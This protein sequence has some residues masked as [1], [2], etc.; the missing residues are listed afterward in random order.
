MSKNRDYPKD[1]QGVYYDPQ[2]REPCTGEIIRRAGE[3][4][5]KSLEERFPGMKGNPGYC[6][7]LWIEKKNILLQKYGI[8]WKSPADLNPG[9][10]FD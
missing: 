4:A 10:R 5:V 3:E 6:R 8:D 9:I 2:E 7:S 1:G